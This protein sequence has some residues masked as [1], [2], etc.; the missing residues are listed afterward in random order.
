M[1]RLLAALGLL[2]LC[3]ITARAQSYAPQDDFLGR[4]D[5]SCPAPG[6]RVDATISESVSGTK[7]ITLPAGSTIALDSIQPTYNGVATNY[8]YDVT[9]SGGASFRVG[10]NEPIIVGN[11]G[12]AMD[13]HYVND[14]LEG[15]DYIQSVTTGSPGSITLTMD[16]NVTPSTIAAT[17][18][19]IEPGRPYTPFTQGT[20]LNGSVLTA[21]WSVNVPNRGTTYPICDPEGHYVYIVANSSLCDSNTGCDSPTSWSLSTTAGAITETAGVVTA[22]TTTAMPTIT[23]GTT[24]VTVRGVSDSSY[25]VSTATTITGAPSAGVIT[26]SVLSACANPTA[27]GGLVTIINGSTSNIETLM[28]ESCSGT[29]VTATFTVIQTAGLGSPVTATGIADATYNCNYYITGLTGN[30]AQLTPA[31]GCTPSGSPTQSGTFKL[32]GY[33]GWPARYSTLGQAAEGLWAEGKGTG[34]NTVGEDSSGDF[35]SGNNSNPWPG[36]P[37][38][39]KG[40]ALSPYGGTVL[41]PQLY[42]AGNRGGFAAQAIHNFV[43]GVDHKFASIFNPPNEELDFPDPNFLAF[44]IN[45]IGPS[46]GTGGSVGTGGNISYYA[47]MSA[48]G[49]MCCD[50]DTYAIPYT[51]AFWWGIQN[52]PDG[53]G[54]AGGDDVGLLAAETDPHQVAANNSSTNDGLPNPMFYPTD[55]VYVKT[56]SA[57]APAGCWAFSTMTAPSAN[58]VGPTQPICGSWLDWE[59]NWYGTVATMNAAYGSNYTSFGSHE[60]VVTQTSPTGWTGNGTTTTFS[61]TLN[62]NV[63]PG[64]LHIYL[65]PGGT[66]PVYFASGDCPWFPTSAQSKGNSCPTQSAGVGTIMNPPTTWLGSNA[67]WNRTATGYVFA[68]TTNDCLWSAT[69]VGSLASTWTATGCSGTQINSAVTWQALGP[70]ITQASSTITYATGALSITFNAAVPSGTIIYV[71]YTFNGFDTVNGTGLGDEDGQDT[72]CGFACGTANVSGTALTWVSGPTFSSLWAGLQIFVNGVSNHI[73]AVN[74]STSITLQASA[75]TGSGVSFNV[76]GFGNNQFC[77][78]TPPTWTSGMSVTAFQTLIASNGAWFVALTSGTTATGSQPTWTM[79]GTPPNVSNWGQVI[80][81]A[82]GIQ[83]QAI[84]PPVCTASG[85]TGHWLA[86]IDAQP[87]LAADINNYLGYGLAASFVN[88]VKVTGEIIMPDAINECSNFGPM[89]Y[90]APSYFQILQAYEYY[91]DAVFLNTFPIQTSDTRGIGASF[92]PVQPAKYSYF[93]SFFNKAIFGE[94]FPIVSAGFDESCAS[95]LNYCV[96][97]LLSR[98]QQY[99]D[100]TT[101]SLAAT[102]PAGIHIDVG[103]TWWGNLGFQTKSFG[104]MDKAGNAPDGHE[105]VT[106]TVACSYFSTVNCGG[107]SAALPFLNADVINCPTCM[108]TAN[109]QWLLLSAVAP[110]KKWIAGTLIPLAQTLPQN[111]TLSPPISLT[112]SRT[113]HN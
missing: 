87:A 106:A 92:D 96:N 100:M 61:T 101:L 94:D 24:K 34:F 40:L 19:W 50:T 22:P 95:E 88:A 54:G 33:T 30:V 103:Q 113:E 31:T 110:T 47:S 62:T 3:S 74:S 98:S 59:R 108:K 17:A 58:P 78:Q 12:T 23:V 20:T 36:T 27:N 112:S 66:G 60:T 75:T 43:G 105:D 9:I 89:N 10:L 68:D 111:R 51:G 44:S 99:Y 39:D 107:E 49:V 38:P 65:Q 11:T 76:N 18:G 1:K 85:G 13:W 5:V 104:W 46:P 32:N 4:S 86:Q 21:A 45:N 37:P 48:V 63:T 73:S 16:P 56:L 84:G 77:I 69:N 71:S 72:G 102:T 80:T 7:T 109:K 82:D 83:W 28:S 91:C 70:E 8:A 90:D 81:G 79:A 14:Q 15:G 42:G 67:S 53:Q 52:A 29:T 35:L 93:T 26:Y 41:S 64:S 2:F 25:N 97:A 6:H 57:V 55:T